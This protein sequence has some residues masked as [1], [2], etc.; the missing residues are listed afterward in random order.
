M[1]PTSSARL[2]PGAPG[3]KVASPG[4]MTWLFESFW[5]WRDGVKEMEE[6]KKV[7]KQN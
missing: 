4:W 5:T 7:N 6:T 2:G 3:A 1:D